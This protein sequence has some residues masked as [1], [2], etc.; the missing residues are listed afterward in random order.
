M[1]QDLFLHHEIL[2]LALH[3]AKGT[4]LTGMHTYAMAGAMLSELLLYERIVANDDK[5]QIIAVVNEEPFGQPL[6]DEFLQMIIDSEKNLGARDWIFKAVKIK[7]FLDKAAG[8]LCTKGILKR[9]Q[10]KLLFMFTQ[11]TYPEVDGTFEDAIRQRMADVMFNEA[12]APDE[13]TAV[14]IAIASHACL[15]APNF[16]PMELKQHK[17]RIKELAQGEILAADATK[18]AIAAVN[19]AVMT[20][21]L[22]P[23]ITSA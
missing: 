5:K 15:L 13:R 14:L 22:I 12:N 7:D 11:K 2:L 8:L 4:S 21:T 9:D 16:A 19:T 6:L 23:I 20:A 3:D 10:R 18:A 1:A 17:Q